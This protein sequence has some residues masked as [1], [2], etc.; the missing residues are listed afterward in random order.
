MNF[1]RIPSYRQ[2]ENEKLCLFES[3]H[4]K[5]K[6]SHDVPSASWRPKKASTVIQSESKSLRTREVN[7]I[8][9]R[10]WNEIFQLFR[11]S[12]DYMMLTHIGQEDLLYFSPPIQMPGSSRNV[13]I[14][15]PR[16][17]LIWILYGLLQ[18]THKVNLHCLHHTFKTKDF[19]INLIVYMFK[20]SSYKIYINFGIF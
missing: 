5:A 15:I 13:L 9:P 4:F 19:I 8:N 1:L 6:K 20:H 18:L 14:D 3:Y 2:R 11:P 16:N 7:N 10:Q 17:C 12:L